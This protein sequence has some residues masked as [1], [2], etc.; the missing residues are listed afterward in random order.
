MQMRSSYVR[1]V[2]RPDHPNAQAGNSASSYRDVRDLE[3]RHVPAATA[4]LEVPACGGIV[5]RR[6]HHLNERVASREHRVCQAELSHAGIVRRPR[7]AKCAAQV[8][9]HLA[10]VPRNHRYLAQAGSRRHTNTI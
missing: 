6:C 8:T 10:A 3:Y 1:K 4:P 9:S 5:L 2:G 7:P